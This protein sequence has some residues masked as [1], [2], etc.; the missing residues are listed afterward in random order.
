MGNPKK[1]QRKNPFFKSEALKIKKGKGSAKKIALANRVLNC[2][3]CSKKADIRGAC[4]TCYAR[5]KAQIERGE[6]TEAKLVRK[7][8][9]LPGKGIAM[10]RDCKIFSSRNKTRGKG[11]A[12]ECRVPWCHSKGYRRSL[13]NTHR[14]EA[15]RMMRMKKATERNLISRDLMTEKKKSLK[16]TKSSRRKAKKQTA[17]K[18][19]SAIKKR[20]KCGKLPAASVCVTPKCKKKRHARWLCKSH[21]NHVMRKLKKLTGAARKRLENDF[22]K[23]CL[24][25]PLKSAKPKSKKIKKRKE[26]SAPSPFEYGSKIRGSVHRY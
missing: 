26:K 8:K 1:H 18:K 21:Y 2:S 9:L 11:K 23:R 25:A 4:E 5:Y 6:T 7:K 3:G 13:C 16:K 10:N 20:S 17:K 24:L 12:G 14:V 15:Y 19:T 22:I